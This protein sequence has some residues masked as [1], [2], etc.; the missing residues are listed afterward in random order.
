M[1]VVRLYHWNNKE[2]SGRSGGS[3]WSTA[4]LEGR[5]LTMGA[6]RTGLWRLHCSVFNLKQSA[7]G[8]PA[9]G[10]AS[11]LFLLKSEGHTFALHNQHLLQ[12]GP[13]L[14]HILLQATTVKGA[15]PLKPRLSGSIV[16][17]SGLLLHP[18]P[19]KLI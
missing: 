13:E 9:G 11:P 12:G 5:L 8:T 19:K 16:R 6:Q 18:A 15:P 17:T 2:R 3:Q 4:A 7:T 14:Q 1:G 10:G